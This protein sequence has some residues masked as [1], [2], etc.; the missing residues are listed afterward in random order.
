MGPCG[1]SRPT[2]TAAGLWRSHENES[3]S[4]IDLLASDVQLLLRGNQIERCVEIA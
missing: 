4:A 2:D 3:G 1:S